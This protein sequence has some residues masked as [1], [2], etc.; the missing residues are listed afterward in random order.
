MCLGRLRC[1]DREFELCRGT[2]TYGFGLREGGLGRTGLKITMMTRCKKYL[3]N[4]IDGNARG[5]Y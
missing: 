3:L 5:K 2:S 1:G 4:I